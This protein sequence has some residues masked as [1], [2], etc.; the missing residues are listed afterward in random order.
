MSPR[1]ESIGSSISSSD[2]GGSKYTGACEC[3]NWF[4]SVTVKKKEVACVKCKAIKTV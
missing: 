2:E 1:F 3:G 4:K